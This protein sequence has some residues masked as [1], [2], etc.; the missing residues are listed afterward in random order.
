MKK[1]LFIVFLFV[2][3]YCVAQVK[4]KNDTINYSSFK[5]VIC[6]ST[7]TPY[8]SRK[9]FPKKRFKPS[10]SDV[11]KFE[12]QFLQQYAEAI[13]K[14]HE[15]FYQE[16]NTKYKTAFTDKEWKEIEQYRKEGKKAGIAAQIKL[17]TEINTHDRFYYGYVG[18]NGHKY[19]RIEFKPH[20]EIWEDVFGIGEAHL[21]NL[22][23]MVY[24]L[25]LN[26]L[27]LA[28]WTGEYDE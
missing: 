10:Y 24:N 5:G 21:R 15:L 4:Y 9:I 16:Y 25:N 1:F 11:R 18:K 20:I 22:P 19:I 12:E 7:F 2:P 8:G 13:K 23:I 14:H 6:D 27:S 28:G 3:I 26:T 17:K